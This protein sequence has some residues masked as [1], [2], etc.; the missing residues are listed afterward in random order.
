MPLVQMT[1][2]IEGDD[3]D[4]GKLSRGIATALRMEVD[5]THKLY[6]LFWES[7]KGSDEHDP[8]AAGSAIPNMVKIVRLRGPDAYSEV[9]TRGRTTEFG[10]RKLM[11]LDDGTSV[12][13]SIVKNWASKTVRGAIRSWGGGENIVV[14]RGRGISQPGV[15][16]RYISYAIAREREPRFQSNIDKVIDDATR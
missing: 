10:N 8:N 3:L 1:A 12:R 16:A 7:W 14:R 15:K 2:I 9:S 5:E 11:W 13:R 4:P 6:A